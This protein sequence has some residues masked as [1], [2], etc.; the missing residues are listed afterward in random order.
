MEFL[1]ERSLLA[2]LS[3]GDISVSESGDYAYFV[4]LNEASEQT[5]IVQFST[6]NGTAASGSDYT[7]VS[8]ALTF[9]PGETGLVVTVPIINDSI[10]EGDETFTLQL[11]NAVNAAIDDAQ[12]TSTIRKNDYAPVI[13]GFAAEQGPGDFWTFYG[14]VSDEDEDPTGWTVAFGG[15][16]EAYGYTATVEEDGTFTLTAEFPGL[17]AGTASAQ[18]TDSEGLDSNLATY[19]VDA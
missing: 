19:Y 17:A 4:V 10:T 16:L 6:S 9:Q 12:A 8:G 1:E 7:A 14:T 13:T 11:S 15:I 5:V 18:T 3:V 2:G